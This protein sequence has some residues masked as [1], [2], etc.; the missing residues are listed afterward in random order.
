M[1]ESG[2]QGKTNDGR[3]RHADRS[4]EQR[5]DRFAGKV[6][7]ATGAGSGIAAA[8]ARRFAAEGGCVAVADL[9]RDNAEAVAVEFDGSIATGCDV[10]DE[11]SVRDAVRT[12]CKQLGRIDCVYNA[13]GHH[14]S[15]RI[16]ECTLEVWNRM[17]AVHATGTFLVCRETLPALRAAG[18]GAIVNTTSSVALIGRPGLGA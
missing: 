17:L 14:V 2:S 11:R 7:F 9:N 3:S 18:G 4:S 13:A 8:T 15:G 16:E 10:A 6:L 12:T 1:S 5:R